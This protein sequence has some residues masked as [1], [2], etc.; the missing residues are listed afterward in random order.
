MS[1]RLLPKASLALLLGLGRL[2]CLVAA[3]V[4]GFESEDGRLREGDCALAD[5]SARFKSGDI[6]VCRLEGAGTMVRRLRMVGA[7][8]ASLESGALGRPPQAV[9]D[10]SKLA[11]LGVAVARA[12][13]L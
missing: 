9:D 7:D 4:E 13:P 2:G 10:L 6:V 8:R 12:G 1:A 11:V 5:T 3:R